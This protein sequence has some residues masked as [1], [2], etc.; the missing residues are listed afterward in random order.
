M[1]GRR[2]LL[3]LCGYGSPLKGTFVPLFLPAPKLQVVSGKSSWM[4]LQFFLLNPPKRTEMK[5]TIIL[6]VSSGVEEWLSF[7]CGVVVREH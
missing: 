2:V 6:S 3:K 7:L 4:D 5:V 1:R